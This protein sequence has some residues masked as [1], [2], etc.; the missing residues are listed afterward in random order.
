VVASE[1]GIWTEWL[2]PSPVASADLQ[3]SFAKAGIEPPPVPEILLPHLRSNQD[4]WAW[5]TAPSLSSWSVYGYNG[6]V[7]T[8]PT[9]PIVLAPDHP[10]YFLCAHRGYGFNSW[11]L[12]ISIRLG[13]ISVTVQ[14]G[15]GGAY[16]DNQRQAQCISNVHSELTEFLGRT[17]LQE[18][19]APCD[20]ALVF[21]PPRGIALVA[22][23]SHER[24]NL[25]HQLLPKGW[26]PVYEAHPMERLANP[27]RKELDNGLDSDGPQDELVG[28]L[29]RIMDGAQKPYSDQE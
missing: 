25:R 23:R 3:V 21:S 13:A 4:G 26:L 1:L 6:A 19:E 9:F 15:W 24:V 29:R 27:G 16:T 20:Y 2:P 8:E 7:N 18:T 5:S 12:G 10:N 28:L 11:L 17:D 22:K 14:D